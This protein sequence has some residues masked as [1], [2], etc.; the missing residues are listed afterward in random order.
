[1]RLIRTPPSGPAFNLALDEALLRSGTP[2]LRFYSWDPPGFSLGF[3]QER[4]SL[5][6]PP[7]FEVVRRPTGGGA[8]AHSGELTVAWVGRRRRVEDV[9]D[10]INTI[11]AN[12][13]GRQW[14]ISAGMG[15]AQPV[16][17]PKGLCFDAHTCYDLLVNGLKV[18]GS[19]QR[20]AGDRFLLHGTLVLEH[21][22]V[23]LGATGL[24]EILNRAVTR[25]EA[26]EAFLTA[27]RH[28]WHTEFEEAQPTEEELTATE[29]LVQSRY[30]NDSW[31]N[32]R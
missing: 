31:T 26:E 3:F 14:S 24:S 7:G 6:A 22:G 12:A 17:A 1:M 28:R 21:N 27:A 10:D 25:T 23:S 11:V 9:Y 29:R 15:R 19:A 20:R 4:E 18:F 16:A 13:L 5:V 30:A 8:I 32:R 2:T